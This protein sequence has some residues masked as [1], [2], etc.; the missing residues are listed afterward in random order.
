MRLVLH[1]GF[2]EK[3]RTSLGVESNGY[4]LLLDAGVKTSARGSDDYYPR[5]LRGAAARHRRDPRDAWARGPRRGARVVH[6][7]RFSRTHL[8]DR[9]DAA[10]RRFVARGLCRAVASPASSRAA[11]VERLP[12]G[13]DAL[14]AWTACASRP[15]GR[16]TSRA[17]CGAAWTTG[18]RGS[19]IAA[20]SFPRARY[21]RWMP[22]RA[23]RRWRSTPRMATTRSG[24]TSAHARSIEWIATHARGCVLPT[25][26]YG[27]SAELLAI[28]PGPVALA[29]GM[30]DALEAQVRGTDWLVSGMAEAL[31]T[32]ACCCRRLVR[33]RS[34]AAR[35]AA[36]PRRHGHGRSGALD[37]RSSRTARVTRRYS[38]G[39]SRPAASAN[40]W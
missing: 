17:A 22:F 25:P 20:T 32:A 27:R 7:A 8:H 19:T 18:E 26:L 1:G 10:G 6:R 9:G 24:A 31:A 21:S 4:R 40:G 35:D 30:R 11:T 3:G 29:P 39:T 23:A 34:I 28:V 37:P 33:R 2:G 15:G 5:D 14:R 38:P 12:L 13:E 36:V 16:V